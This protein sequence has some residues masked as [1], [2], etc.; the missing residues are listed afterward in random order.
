MAASIVRGS[1]IGAAA[2]TAVLLIV[3][4]V[5]FDNVTHAKNV[6]RSIDV[7][8]NLQT[9]VYH[10]KNPPL[11]AAEVGDGKPAGEIMLVEPV[12]VAEGADGSVY[13]SDRGHRIWRVGGDG[14]ARVVAG[15][16]YKGSIDPA[17]NPKDSRLGIPEGLAVDRQGRVYFAD[18]YND[19]VARVNGSGPIEIVAGTGVRGFNGEEGPATETQLNKPYDVAVDRAGNV[20]IVDNRS[21]RLRKVTPNG[22]MST[23]VG[24]GERGPS[25]DP[26]PVETARLL[27]PWGVFVDDRG[28]IYIA[29]GEHHVI[30]RVD[31]DGTIETVAG[32]GT[33]GYAGDGGPALEARLNDPQSVYLRND[34]SLLI[35]DEHNHA[36]R[37][38]H[39]DGTISTIA[40]T[41]EPSD[42]LETK[43]SSR[44]G[45]NDPEDVIERLDGKILI[46]DRM[47]HRVIAIN[48][49]G[50]SAVFAG[51]PGQ[52]QTNR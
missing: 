10:L 47:N 46:A 29:D 9:Y 30:R 27:S 17:A 6:L 22:V 14:I 39:P 44:I 50:T 51:R 19:V 4:F 32:N 34:G 48:P 16:G 23:P 36:I 11:S 26:Q 42:I 12:S 33:L 52:T 21:N 7:V 2:A 3:Y 49:N 38:V 18:S 45:L 5:S 40:G 15:N 37:L 43:A 1:L 41:G 20:F 24:A 31:L 28:R 13:I 35:N 25:S 8:R